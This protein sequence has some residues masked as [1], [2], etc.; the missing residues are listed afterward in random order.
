M[1]R[2]ASV[3]LCSALVMGLLSAPA[4]ALK[5]VV[6]N[7]EE[8]KYITPEEMQA[9]EEQ[10][11]EGVVP[12]TLEGTSFGPS[13]EVEIPE[14]GT[15]QDIPDPG[16]SRPSSWAE[17]EIE[18]ASMAGL[19][20]D[21]T[22]DPDFQ[23]PITREQFAEL[24]FNA[25]LRIKDGPTTIKPVSFTDTDNKL[26]QRAAG[27]GIVNGVGEG[28]FDPKATTNREQIA[29][30]LYRAWGL[31]GTPAQSQGLDAYADGASVSSW[32]A[33]AVGAMAASGIMKGTSDV[34]LSPADPCTVEQA[35]LLVYRLY[36]EVK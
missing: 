23:D 7:P 9:L 21:F 24:A 20:V 26:V 22:D 34:T 19:I 4:S 17:S 32:A 15:P 3:F 11:K 6:I 36:Q 16:V 14:T 25:V 13:I 5:G 10:A 30:M 29:T 33:D 1:K 12:P 18:E 31:V 27:L 35:I 2:I 28:R 8:A